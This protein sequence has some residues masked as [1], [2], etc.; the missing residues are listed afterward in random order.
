MD[1]EL[2]LNLIY[3][4]LYIEFNLILVLKEIIYDHVQ[5]TMNLRVNKLQ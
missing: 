2:D 3:L 1:L 5:F 4:D